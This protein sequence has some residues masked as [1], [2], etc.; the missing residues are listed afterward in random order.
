ME[1]LDK[2]RSAMKPSK[3]PFDESK[4]TPP[5]RLALELAKNQG[6]PFS[7]RL[8]DLIPDLGLTQD[9]ADAFGRTLQQIREESRRQTPSDPFEG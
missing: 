7:R 1:D 6:V 8:E 2:E 3:V 9:E 5:Q 4:L